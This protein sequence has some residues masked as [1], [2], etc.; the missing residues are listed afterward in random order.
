[1]KSYKYRWSLRPQADLSLELCV[2]AP[3]VVV[4]R[5][6]VRQFLSE[7]DGSSW[8]IECIS[9]EATQSAAEGGGFFIRQP[10]RSA[11]FSRWHGVPA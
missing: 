5:R 1:M 4:A 9:R 3:S 8:V 11:A 2:I 6:E 7:H 10:L